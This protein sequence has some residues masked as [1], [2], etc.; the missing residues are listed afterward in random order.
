MSGIYP[1]SVLLGNA[2]GSKLFALLAIVTC[3]L[4]VVWMYYH[5]KGSS[6]TRPIKDKQNKTVKIPY[7]RNSSAG[8]PDTTSALL[9]KPD[10]ISV[11]AQ[12]E[13]MKDT[14]ALTNQDNHI[15][16]QSLSEARYK[17]NHN[18]I[19]VRGVKTN[20]GEPNFDCNEEV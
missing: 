1:L 20:R 7:F 15:I 11:V 16:M 13:N 17:V 6:L 12:P 3:I 8:S 5:Q 10:N 9:N 18:K 19:G 2:D 14:T 4:I